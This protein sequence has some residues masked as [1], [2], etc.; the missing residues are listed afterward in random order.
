MG[1]SS[2][3]YTCDTRC[4]QEETGWSTGCKYVDKG[5]WAT[6]TKYQAYNCVA[7]Y[8]GQNM[9]AGTAHFSCVNNGKVTIT[10]T[11]ADGWELAP[12][13]ESV[14]IQGYSTA[15]DSKPSPGKFAYKGSCLTVEVCA[16]C[17][18]GIHL[19]LRKEVACD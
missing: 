7:I 1:E 6:Y 17:F 15:P 18:Y 19:D 3:A 11:L 5:S 2:S 13:N 9:Y 4:W 12:G 14:K 8:A 16:S 10:I